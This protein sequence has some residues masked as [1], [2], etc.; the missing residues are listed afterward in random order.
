MSM[1]RVYVISCMFLGLVLC[2]NIVAPNHS[3]KKR[4]LR[5][6]QEPVDAQPVDTDQA[7][8]ELNESD[9]IYTIDTI[10][11]VL[12]GDE[13]TD[14]I[15]LSDV[16]RP[17]LDGHQRSLEDLVLER[18]MYQDA[19]RYKMLPTEDAVIKRLQAVQRDNKLSKDDLERIFRTS[20]Y[21]YEEGKELFAIM[22]AV[23]TVLDFKIMSRLIVPEKDII[24]YYQEH[25][26][27]QDATFQLERALVI[28]PPGWTN[29]KFKD[30]L[31]LL[32]E[33][34]KSCLEIDWSNSFWVNKGDLAADKQFITTMDIDSIA[35]VQETA[36]GVEL[37]KLL[38]R[39]DE[40]LMS[41]EDRYHEIA[42]LLKRPKYEEMFKAYKD[43]LLDYAAILYF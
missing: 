42:D 12:F 1:K 25:P 11:A 24:T 8:P 18:A 41:L 40:H 20:G 27:M 14:I 21:T 13:R 16:Q 10:K 9:D 36:A 7:L 30:E 17:S 2:C 22:T 43:E 38:N 23:G 39:R 3:S 31:K 26:V 35:I 4:Q 6:T 5:Q 37:L 28:C 15:T 32:I 33:S 34:G 29:D 19:A